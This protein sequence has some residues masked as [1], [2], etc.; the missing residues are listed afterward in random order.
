MKK[1][2]YP[3]AK[4]IT[5][6]TNIKI[7]FGEVD[8]MGI[9]WH[10][11]YVKY[12]EDAREEF[13]KKYGLGYMDVY[14]N[15]GFMLPIVKLD[16]DYKNQ[17]FYGDEAEMTISIIENPASKLI[18]EYE[19][20]RKKDNLLILNAISIQVFMNSNRKLELNTPPFFE[21][22]KSDNF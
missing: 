13:G 5:I 7:R 10:G 1:N 2:K 22:W 17:L 18:F 20:R 15:F 4:R 12:L 11:N 6:K 14:N 3:N 9:V 21:K 16:I 8:S 19:L